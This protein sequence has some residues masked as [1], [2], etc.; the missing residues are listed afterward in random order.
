MQRALLLYNP[1]AGG[2]SKRRQALLHELASLIRTAQIEL[3]VEASGGPGQ[4][5]AQVRAAIDSG[6][7]TVFAAGGDGTVNDVLQA[8]VGTDTAL[9]VIPLGTANAL[10]HDLEIPLNP[11]RAAHTALYGRPRRY[12]VGK[13]EYI[14]F[15]G[16][17]ES[18]YFTVAAGVGIDAHMFYKL[19]QESKRRLGMLAYYA[20]ATHLWL[21][22]EME[23]F[24]AEFRND[25]SRSHRVDVSELLAVRIRN[26]GAVLREFAPG[27]SLESDRFRLVLFQTKNRFRYLHYLLRG[28]L[29]RRWTVPGIELKDATWVRCEL[30]TSAQGKRIYVE[31]DGELAGTVPVELSIVPNAVTILTPDRA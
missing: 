22:H 8:L 3:Q 21:T 7:D 20:K 14:N 13:A 30:D 18:R 15:L 27:A 17:R 23:F 16:Q 12:A 1:F 26:F 9:A 28:V 5:P 24:P 19:N 6:C 10:A 25:D 11:L 29:G 2:R 31:A 4:T